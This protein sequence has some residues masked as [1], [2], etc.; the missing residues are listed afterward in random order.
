[1]TPEKPASETAKVIALRAP[2]AAKASERKWGK[3]VMDLGFSIIPSLLL[4][5]QPRLKLSPTQLAVL[6]H[7]ADYWW[8]VDRKPFPSKATL[9]E[10]LGLSPRQVQR[11][12]AELEDMG[13]LKRNQRYAHHRGKISNEYD[14]SGLVKRLKELEPE[15]REVEEVAKSSRR[16]VARP[17]LRKRIKAPG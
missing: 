16:A 14:L 7:L 12:T 10:R 15:F 5:A 13:Y 1:M 17:G 11:Y 2:T 6:M 4:R 3:G 8:D 9:G